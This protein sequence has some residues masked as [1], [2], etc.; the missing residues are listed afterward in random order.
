MLIPV[1]VEADV[2]ATLTA[3]ADSV[4]TKV[5]N[6]RPSS[7]SYIRVRRTGGGA[8]GPVQS[9]P[10]LLVECWAPDDVAAFALAANAYGRLQ[11][12]YGGASVWGGRIALTDPVNYAD[13]DTPCP[14]Y[15]FIATLTVP[16]EELTS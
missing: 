12:A 8:L 13:P 4:A 16:L 14:R 7:G 15:Q 2:I 9:A 1:D 6:P 11:A 5:P 10:T 3:A